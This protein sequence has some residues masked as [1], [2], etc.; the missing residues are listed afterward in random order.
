MKA[1]FFIGTLEAGGAQKII[2]MLANHYALSGWDVD[3]VVLLGKKVEGSHFQLD[4]SVNIVDLTNGGDGSYIKKAIPWIKKIRKYLKFSS[5]DVIVSFIGRINALVLT[6][7]L[8]L[9]IPSLVSE[10]SDPRR[11]HR[12]EIMLKYCNWIYGRSDAVVFQTRYQQSCFSEKLASKSHIIVNPLDIVTIEDVTEDPYLVTTTGRLHVDKHHVDL[13]KAM[14]IVHEKI[15]SAKCIIYGDGEMRSILQEEIDN[16]H[17]NNV[18]HLPGK[19]SEVVK[20]VAEGKV[21]VM[22]S[23]Y[24]GLSNALMEAMMLGKVC[25]STNYDGVEDIIKDSTT[26]IIVPKRE[27]KKLADTIIDVMT[28][29][30]GKYEIIRQKAKEQAQQYDSNKVLSQ[31]DN[32][33]K[34]IIKK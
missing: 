6:A 31:W 16:L 23:E 18:V 17:L 27:Y 22:T 25:I 26:G 2:T 24:E 30:S 33:I 7:S 14:A 15:P 28:D 9:K 34:N 11:D 19:T 8:G 1:A 20:K 12:G 5:P 4:Q 32:V 10:R 3:I 29:N 13:V 21:F